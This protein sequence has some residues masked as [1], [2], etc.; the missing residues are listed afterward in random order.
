MKFCLHD[1]LLFIFLHCV[2][3]CIYRKKPM[4]VRRLRLLFS[5]QI[6]NS[7]DS[8]FKSTTRIIFCNKSFLATS[9]LMSSMNSSCAV[10]GTSSTLTV[11][12]LLASA[13]G[14]SGRFGKCDKISSEGM[15]KCSFTEIIIVILFSGS[16]PFSS[17][18][19]D[20]VGN[21]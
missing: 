8:L 3:N 4:S 16:M 11:N 10:S 1:L 13:N 19:A 7:R 14:V 20:K 15:R 18:K 2:L 12:G 17:K 5:H 21:M 6:R 9:L